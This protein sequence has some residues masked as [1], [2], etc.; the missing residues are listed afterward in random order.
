MTFTRG[1]FSGVCDSSRRW[2]QHPHRHDHRARVHPAAWRDK[3]FLLATLSIFQPIG[4]V[5]RSAIAFGF[6]PT[7]SCS[8]DLSEAN[9]P[10]LV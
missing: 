6:I 7:M 1:S 8:P 2:R 3:R 9:P 4:V 10:A 5:V